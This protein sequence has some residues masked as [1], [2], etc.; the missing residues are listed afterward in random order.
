MGSG[1]GDADGVHLN[2]PIDNGIDPGIRYISNV[3]HLLHHIGQSCSSFGHGFSRVV[4]LGLATLVGI[5]PVKA[6]RVT[7]RDRRALVRPYEANGE[8]L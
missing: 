1:A 5:F 7:E 6:G 4:V 8:T 2:V 3:F